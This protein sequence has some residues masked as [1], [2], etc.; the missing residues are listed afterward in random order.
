MGHIHD[1]KEARII[2]RNIDRQE[3]LGKRILQNCRHELYLDFPYLDGAFASLEY[4]ADNS[5]ITIGTDGEKIYFNP[6]FLLKQ[7]VEDP[8]AVRRGYLHMLL[9]CLYLH[10]FMMPDKGTDE[11]N[12]ECDSFV[13]NL[14]D[15]FVQESGSHSLKKRSLNDTEMTDNSFDDHTLWQRT[16]GQMSGGRRTKEKW[17][18]VLA[19]T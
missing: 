19:Y 8:V 16:A 4:E 5:M 6:A 13:E 7:Y 10:I 2:M 15:K 14:I 1:Q 3:L 11:W 9:H 17:E 12:R 18:R